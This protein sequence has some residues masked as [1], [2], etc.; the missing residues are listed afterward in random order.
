MT[1]E[2]SKIIERLY[3]EMY[4][5]LYHYANASLKNPMLAEEAVQE[6]FRI[7]CSKPDDFAGAPNPKGWLVNTIRNITRNMLRKQ[8]GADGLI[9]Q[10]AVHQTAIT[11]HELPLNILYGS[12]AET[13][14][15]Q[16]LEDLS[17]GTPI[18]ELAQRAG[19]TEASCR[20]RIQR[21]RAR[22]KKEI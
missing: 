21:A 4:D 7:A 10:L 8:A 17:E 2:Q 22:L 15:F 12:L 16:L 1:E 20:K 11:R 19:I 3:L 9:E 14:D 18:R 6:T 5:M 13:K